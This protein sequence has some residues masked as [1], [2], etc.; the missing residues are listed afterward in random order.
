MRN[1]SQNVFPRPF[2]LGET[3]SSWILHISERKS[4]M[5]I[6]LV[7]NLMWTYNHWHC[8][9]M[10]QYLYEAI[11]SNCKSRKICFSVPCLICGKYV[12]IGNSVFAHILFT[13]STMLSVTASVIINLHNLSDVTV[14][15]GMWLC[16]MWVKG[17]LCRDYLAPSLWN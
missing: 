16:R 2:F 4:S 7:D 11:V 17:I 9:L 14:T 8:C 10:K 3:M 13:R 15:C 12:L 5:I 1:T 6:A